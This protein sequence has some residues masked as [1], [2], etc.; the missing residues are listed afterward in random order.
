[1]KTEFH[2]RLTLILAV[3]IMALLAVPL[4]RVNPRQD[5]F[6][7]VLPALL[8]YLI[9]F[10]LQSSLKSAGGAGKLDVSLFMLLVNIV[11]FVLAIFLNSWNSA[12]MYRIRYSFGKQ[13]TK[14]E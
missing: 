2:W 11:F 9:Y 14:Q 1:M 13:E 5:H 3:P 8:L 12:F 6:A 10:L 4:S 7:K